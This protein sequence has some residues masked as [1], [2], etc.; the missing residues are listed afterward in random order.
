MKTL[1]FIAVATFALSSAFAEDHACCA[2]T[3]RHEMKGA[4]ST[5]FANLNLTAAQKGK[6]EKLAAQCDKEGCNDASMA[7]MEKS[8]KGILSKD[9]FAAWKANCS[10]KMSKK[11]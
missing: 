2:G 6:M 4:C 8:A 5:T 11:A 10:E 3:A 9:Q 1:A 7:K